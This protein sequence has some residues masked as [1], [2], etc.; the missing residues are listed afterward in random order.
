MEIFKQYFDENEISKFKQKIIEEGPS[1]KK[2]Y[3]T[4][5]ND[6]I[7]KMTQL[8]ERVK[9]TESTFE[10]RF[11]TFKKAILND[12]EKK[13]KS[14]ILEQP[15]DSTRNSITNKIDVKWE[16]V[17][18][19]WEK[20][21]I[22]WM[23]W[24][25]IFEWVEDMKAENK[26]EKWIDKFFGSIVIK[27]WTAILGMFGINKMYDEFKKENEVKSNIEPQVE[28]TIQEKQNQRPL[29]IAQNNQEQEKENTN[30]I[31]GFN[32][33]LS[34]SW[35]NFEDNTSNREI[36]KNLSKVKYSEFKKKRNEN[37]FI[38]KITKENKEN[39]KNIANWF[40]SENVE[41]L[42]KEWLNKERVLKIMMWIDK[43]EENIKLKENI[44]KTRFEYMLK[45]INA[46]TFNYK[47]L[48]IKEISE[49]YI[50]TIPSISNWLVNE[51]IKW[52]SS[53]VSWFL[54]E[55]EEIKWYIEAQK[56]N[57][58]SENLI[59]Q[60][61]EKW[62]G[63][64]NL[65]KPKEEIIA[66]LEI[67]DYKDK[68]DFEKL[69]KFKDYITGDFLENPILWLK[70]DEKDKLK[71][72]LNYRNILALY[73]VMWW[74]EIWELSAVNLPILIL[75]LNKI[76]W[77][78]NDYLSD[79]MIWSQLVYR[80][81][82]KL[83]LKETD[84]WLTSEQIK[85]LDIYR[86]KLLDILF[87]SHLKDF[88]GTLGFV[89]DKDWMQNLA[90]W[91]TW[92][93][94]LSTYIWNKWIQ[95]ALK[96]NKLPFFSSK[97]KIWWWIGT[98]FWLVLWWLSLMETESDIEK[99]DKDLGE[100]YKKGN[101]KKII[102]IIEKQKEWLKK[103]KKDEKDIFLITYENS[104]PYVIYDWKVYNFI[105]IDKTKSI[106]ESSSTVDYIISWL[107][108]IIAEKDLTKNWKNI[109]K[110]WFKEWKIT[111]WENVISVDFEKTFDNWSEV[112]VDESMFAHLDTLIKAVNPDYKSTFWAWDFKNIFK[113]SDIPSTNF[114]LWLAPVWEL[115]I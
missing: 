112:K 71:T 68:K 96:K 83:L 78:W 72:K 92:A 61:I 111:L 106:K 60:I 13:Q 108:S 100:A 8:Q 20:W 110:I 42:L 76:I 89:I 18:K 69:Y 93:W 94:M 46:D 104:T 36:E 82:K 3:E 25:A 56:Q 67:T 88:Y 31:L 109:A 95:K 49:L 34:L 1:F 63:K 17:K 29:E 24:P 32:L 16:F 7:Y 50:L 39:Y 12:A 84:T 54:S 19:L 62:W 90:M 87:V 58:F 55:S 2:K 27:F 26:K 81:T 22:T 11:E 85:V 75:T 48:T 77:S 79:S 91:L 47:D 41:I 35:Q 103:Y 66:N 33:L 14:A 43:N 52:F 4:I 5:K 99:I 86:D 57:V 21:W 73:W 64:E 45:M 15:L 101:I 40:L 97:L 51:W 80:F 115:Q 107:T 114:M 98:A 37:S 53:V 59:K 74:Y 28:T 105:V 38:E 44:W 70:P 9:K 65:S 23:I 6:P 10:Q 30:Y 113:I 102:N